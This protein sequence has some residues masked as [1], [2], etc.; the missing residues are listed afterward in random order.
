MWYGNS[1]VTYDLDAVV[2][3]HGAT[4][5][6]GHYTAIVREDK[7]WLLC[8]DNQVSYIAYKGL[9]LFITALVEVNA[10]TNANQT[11]SSAVA[12]R[13]RNAARH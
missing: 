2:V 9:R 5:H 10:K 13:P 12:E 3:H 6:S 1:Q 11:G 7:K 8:D 4:V